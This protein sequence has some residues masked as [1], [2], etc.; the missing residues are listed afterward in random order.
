VS[1]SVMLT[2]RPLV[3]GPEV[4]RAQSRV[5]RADLAQQFLQALTVIGCEVSNYLVLA[6]DVI[7]PPASRATG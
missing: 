6:P 2:D 5:D 3:R 4:Q 1:L 7:V